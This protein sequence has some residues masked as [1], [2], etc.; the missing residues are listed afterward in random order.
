M[1]IGGEKEVVK[2]HLVP[3]FAALAPGIGDIPRTTGREKI[4]GT[5]KHGYLHCGPNGAS[6]FVK[7]VHN[8]IE[9]GV[10]AAYAQGAHGIDYPM[11]NRS[12]R[13]LWVVTG[14]GVLA[15]PRD[16]DDSIPAGRI[17]REGALVIAD[18]AAFGELA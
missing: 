4:G 16:A 13:I 17:R 7:M 6:H 14:D 11:L 1:M 8:C 18:R 9:Y 15:R 3:I 12:R 2:R 5:A 10:M